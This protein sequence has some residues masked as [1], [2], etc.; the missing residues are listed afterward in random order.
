MKRKM[1]VNG[2]GMET[3]MLGGGRFKILSFLQNKAKIHQIF[4]SNDG[5]KNSI[6]RL[7]NNVVLRKEA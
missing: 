3:L 1:V 7:S 6:G 5:S 4:Q 2:G